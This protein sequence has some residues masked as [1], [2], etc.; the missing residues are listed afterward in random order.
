MPFFCIQ[1]FNFCMTC[2][3][4]IGY[5]SYIPNIKQWIE[6]QVSLCVCV[7]VCVYVYDGPVMLI[8]QR[9]VAEIGTLCL[10]V[11]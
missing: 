5:F 2:L 4:G 11:M 6:A 1:V 8:N 9:A 10:V 7:C 3:S